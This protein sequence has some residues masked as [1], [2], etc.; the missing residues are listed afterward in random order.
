MVTF[1]LVHTGRGFTGSQKTTVKGPSGAFGSTSC[2]QR[3][4]SGRCLLVLVFFFF[5]LP[6]CKLPECK[7]LNLRSWPLCSKTEQVDILKWISVRVN[8]DEVRRGG[9]GG[10]GEKKA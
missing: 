6:L 3:A 9:R 1:C 5:L 7:G 4:T 8:L 2:G 10:R